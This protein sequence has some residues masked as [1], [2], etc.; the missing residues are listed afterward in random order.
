MFPLHC[1]SSL[2]VEYGSADGTSASP[3]TSTANAHYAYELSSVSSSISVVEL[4][5]IAHSL[6]LQVLSYFFGFIVIL[7]TVKTAFLNKNHFYYIKKIFFNKLLLQS[8]FFQKIFGSFIDGCT[9]G[10]YEKSG[11]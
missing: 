10:R 11:P 7:I 9:V 2:L 1:I 5:L 4:V 3:H 8:F 6:F